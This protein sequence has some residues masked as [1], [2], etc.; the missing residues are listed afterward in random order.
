VATRQRIL[1]TAAVCIVTVIT[2]VSP[3]FAE[4]Y[5]GK[6]RGVDREKQTIVLEIQEGKTKELTVSTPAQMQ[7]A[8]VG[9]NVVVETSRDHVTMIRM[10][11]APP[12]DPLRHAP[13]TSQSTTEGV[14]PK[15]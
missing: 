2:Q 15:N 3:A 12:E 11:Q 6:A 13:S 14:P 9:A 5:V 7:E 10:I 1:C 4:F 8:Q